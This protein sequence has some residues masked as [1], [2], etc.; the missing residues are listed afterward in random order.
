VGH[1]G[2]NV[3]MAKGADGAA[4]AKR[5]R[6]DTSEPGATGA[7]SADRLAKAERK[8]LEN[9]R[10]AMQQGRWRKNYLDAIRK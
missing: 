2:G 7:L 10:E 6:G 5:P 3:G 1:A 8:Y 4:G 9:T